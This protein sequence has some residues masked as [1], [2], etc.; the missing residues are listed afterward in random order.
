MEWFWVVAAVVILL[1]IVIV[2]FLNPSETNKQ[3]L[4]EIEVARI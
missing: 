2:F 4:E 3:E 1:P